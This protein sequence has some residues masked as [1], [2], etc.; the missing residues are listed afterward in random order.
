VLLTNLN[1]TEADLTEADLAALRSLVP[2]TEP[3]R[4]P[5]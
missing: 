1:D 2:P 4:L 5:R 3:A